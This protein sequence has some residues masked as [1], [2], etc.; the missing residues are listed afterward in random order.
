MPCPD[1][2][3]YSDPVGRGA[4]RAILQQL[5]ASPNRLLGQ[6]FLVDKN[7]RDKILTTAR[8]NESDAVLEIGPG[9]GALTCKLVGAAG[10]VAAVEKDRVLFDYLQA[11]GNS[12]NLHLVSGDALRVDWSTLALPDENVKVVAN[13]PY[14]I[15]KPFLRRVYEEWRPHLQSATL[16][17]QKEVAE[18][19]VARPSTGA[20]G[21]MAIMAGLWS[22]TKIAFHLSPGAFFPPPEISSSVV[23]IV[24]RDSPRVVVDNE[25]FFWRVVTAAFTQRRKQLANTLRAVVSD[26]AILTT[27][28]LELNIDPQRRGE[29]LSLEEFAALANHLRIASTTPTQ[30]PPEGEE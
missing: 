23:H 19:L 5:D 30:P 7:A 3:E 26:K 11:H 17:L 8:V 2:L 10:Q 1:F 13:L 24:L 14:S 22:E 6:N 9:L 12:P 27:A 29:T 15:S 4:V 25:K 20:F 18:R 16:M 28:M 21:P